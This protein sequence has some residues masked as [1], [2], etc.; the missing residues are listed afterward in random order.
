MEYALEI[1]NLSKKYKEF[2]LKDVSLKLEKGYIMGFIGPNGAGKSTVIRLIMNLVKKNHGD[3]SIF[4]MD[5][6]KYEKEVKQ[7]I[8]FVY[9]ENYFY[10]DLSMEAMKNIVATFYKGWNDNDFSKY[11]KDFD[12]N[13]KAKIKTLSK[14]MKMKFSL[15]MALSHGAELIIMDEPTAGLDPVFRSELLDITREIIQDENKSIFFSTH[16]TTDLEKAADYITFI[17][18]GKIEFSKSKDEIM[19]SYHIVKG[20]KVILD[21]DTKGHF[22]SIRENSYGF[23]ALTNDAAKVKTIFRDNVMIEKASLEDIMVYTVRGQQC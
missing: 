10:E 16:I 9:D 21:S 12:L 2:E 7:R 6:I 5:N 17:N 1:K 8:G 23:E 3:I 19:E 4:G 15:A 20:D 22:L 13:R 11:M 18:K 14:G